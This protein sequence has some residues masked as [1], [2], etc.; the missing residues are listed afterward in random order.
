[1]QHNYIR[2][3]KINAYYFEDM[4]KRTCIICDTYVL[5]L[6]LSRVVI[7]SITYHTDDGNAMKAIQNIM[8]S[9]CT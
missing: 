4:I 6:Q 5:Y 7:K 9:A 2:E 1:M 3:N 8:I